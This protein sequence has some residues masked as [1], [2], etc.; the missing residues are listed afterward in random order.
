MFRWL[1]ATKLFGLLGEQVEHLY[2]MVLNL[3]C[4][5]HNLCFDFNC[6]QNFISTGG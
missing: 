1:V 6:Q 2:A 4:L 3:L 5:I